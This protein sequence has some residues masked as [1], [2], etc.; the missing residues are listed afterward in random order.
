M[1]AIQ[2]GM[3]V[4]A[5]VKDKVI[6]VMKPDVAAKVR[7][8]TIVQK[9]IMANSALRSAQLTATV[10]RDV[11]GKPESVLNVWMDGL[12]KNVLAKDIV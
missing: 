4:T 7:N 3:E 10:W 8:V 11:S 9:V 6:C 5:I 1:D 2:V 12:E